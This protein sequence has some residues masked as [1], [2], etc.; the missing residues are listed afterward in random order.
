MVS[1]RIIFFLPLLTSVAC[2]NS[3]PCHYTMSGVFRKKEW[4]HYANR[5]TF[6]LTVTIG[7]EGGKHE[8][9]L[10]VRKSLARASDTRKW[11]LPYS[12][13]EHEERNTAWEGHPQGQSCSPR[14]VGW[15]RGVALAQ[16]WRPLQERTVRVTVPFVRFRMAT[17]SSWVTPSRLCPLTAMIWSP[18][19]RRPSSEAAP[20]RCKVGLLT[21]QKMLPHRLTTEQDLGKNISGP[22]GPPGSPSSWGTPQPLSKHEHTQRRPF[23]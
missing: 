4:F 18:L 8:A 12:L 16:F 7:K 19:F 9:R 15:E 14:R 3:C 13:E 11:R 6:E 1:F 2:S 22:A 21:S 23:S 20:C 5:P 17:A 10:S